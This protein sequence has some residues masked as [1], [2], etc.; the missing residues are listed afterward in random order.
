MK[1]WQRLAA[2][3]AGQGLEWVGKKI[4]RTPEKPI[5]RP[6]RNRA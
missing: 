2:W 4:A 3:A 1:W 5:K 6:K